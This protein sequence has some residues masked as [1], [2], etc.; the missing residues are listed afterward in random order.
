MRA[1][2]SDIS[3]QYTSRY[4]SNPDNDVNK[5]NAIVM[6]DDGGNG[7]MRQLVTLVSFFRKRESL[8][9]RS[10]L[11]EHITQRNS[12]FDHLD[13]QLKTVIK[14]VQEMK[15]SNQA[16]QVQVSK[17][18]SDSNGKLTRLLELNKVNVRLPTAQHNTINSHEPNI[19]SLKTTVSALPNDTKNKVDRLQSNLASKLSD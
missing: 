1:D 14:P 15:Q 13:R 12:W 7:L 11:T 6:Y 18:Q 8:A 2:G 9:L 3:T 19:R 10:Q 5:Q 16:A 4:G 17:T